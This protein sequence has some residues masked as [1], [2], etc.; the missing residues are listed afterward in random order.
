MQRQV[1]GDKDMK[2]N[3]PAGMPL[4]LLAEDHPDD[5]F[6]MR[7]AL[8]KSGLANPMAVA[9]GGLDV[10]HYLEGDGQYADRQRYPLP[11]LL[12]LDLKMPCVDGFDVLDWLLVHPQ[13]DQLPVV[14]LSNSDLEPDVE[15]ATRLGA[16]D[17][18]LKPFATADSTLMLQKLHA[19]WLSGPIPPLIP[20]G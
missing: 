11:S 8:A 2:P 12:L 7:R 3:L 19:R 15:K 16:D 9:S 10:I 17:Y 18:Y 14:V 1:D 20:P 13:F 6:L 4:I 5:V